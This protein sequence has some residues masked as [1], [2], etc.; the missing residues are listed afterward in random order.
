M[1]EIILFY[2]LLTSFLLTILILISLYIQPRIWITKLPQKVQNFIPEKTKKEKIQAFV[3]FFL[4]IVILFLFPVVAVTQ[5][6]SQPT[7]LEIWLITFSIYFIFNL[8][9]LLI[10][11]WLIICTITPGFI[12]INGVDISVYKNYSKHL[13]DFFKGIILMAVFSFLSSLISCFISQQI[14]S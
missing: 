7:F 11:D 14:H 8:T 2:G 6:V 13:I 10:I 12:Q 9:D 5:Y 1:S 4:F 3:V